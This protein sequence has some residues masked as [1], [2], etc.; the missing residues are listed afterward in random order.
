[1]RVLHNRL[2]FIWVRLSVHYF[3]IPGYFLTL[4]FSS[5][6]FF[7][8]HSFMKSRLDSNSQSSCLH[9]WNGMVALHVCITMPSTFSDFSKRHFF[10]QSMYFVEA[11]TILKKSTLA[12]NMIK[13]CKAWLIST[14]HISPVEKEIKIRK[15][16]G[17][18][19]FILMTVE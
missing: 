3:A 1:M 10:F 13:I 5:M 4:L 2:C 14:N 19:K 6:I 9:L 16:Y 15:R 17:I 11:C 8:I 18:S 7:W 12:L